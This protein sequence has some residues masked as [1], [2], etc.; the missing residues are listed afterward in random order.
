MSSCR[1]SATAMGQSTSVRLTTVG[2]AALETYTRALQA[3]LVPTGFS[4]AGEGTGT[5]R[6]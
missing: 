1:R 6:L 3:L 4:A 2:R 5:S